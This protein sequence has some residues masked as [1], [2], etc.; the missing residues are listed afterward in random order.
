MTKTSH[1]SFKKYLGLLE[2]KQFNTFLQSLL[3]KNN[4]L[5]HHEVESFKHY[6][7]N[8]E[9]DLE[10]DFDQNIQLKAIQVINFLEGYLK[11]PR[12]HLEKIGVTNDANRYK[13]EYFE[14]SY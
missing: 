10:Y 11:L 7:A 3:D 4:S 6:F 1:I 5:I 12:V 9:S 14:D 2:N 13:H 8:I